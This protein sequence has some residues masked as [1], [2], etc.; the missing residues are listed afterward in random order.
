MDVSLENAEFLLP[1]EICRLPKV[2]GLREFSEFHRNPNL[3]GK[4]TEPLTHLTASSTCGA[5]GYIACILFS[6]AVIL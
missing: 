6:G 2:Q 4:R 1:A 3:S 5:L